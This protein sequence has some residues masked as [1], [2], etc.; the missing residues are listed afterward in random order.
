MSTENQPPFILMPLERFN[1]IEEM[2]NRILNSLQNLAAPKSEPN[3]YLTAQEFMEKTHICRSKFDDM[4]NNN[5]LKTIKK[6]RK[7]YVPA[8]ELIRYFEG[9]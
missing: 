1:S 6:G 8:S 2:Q 4:R 3:E 9:K 5:E 7:I